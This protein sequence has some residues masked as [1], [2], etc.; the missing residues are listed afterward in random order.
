M[1]FNLNIIIVIW[2]RNQPGGKP[3][4]QARPHPAAG[5]TP[6]GPTPAK[7]ADGKHIPR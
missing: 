4:P 6:A 3:A 7:G 5:R 1:S 2:M